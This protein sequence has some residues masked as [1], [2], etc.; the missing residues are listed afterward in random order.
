MPY[1]LRIA[2]SVTDYGLDDRGS[3]P[4][5]ERDFFFNPTSKTALRP[6]QPPI[7][8]VARIQSPGLQRTDRETD[9]LPQS[10]AEVKNAWSYAF[11]SSI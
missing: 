9:S 11:M 7:R 5:R 4:D 6:T 10:T 8:W 2:L 3:I 1:L